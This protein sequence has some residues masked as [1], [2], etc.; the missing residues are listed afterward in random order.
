MADALHFCQQL[1]QLNTIPS[2]PDTSSHFGLNSAPPAPN[3]Q[4]NV[5]NLKERER[6]AAGWLQKA[7]IVAVE[8]LAGAGAECKACGGT[9]RLPCPLCSATG[10]EVVEL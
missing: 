2:R 3:P 9:G 4:L 6:W 5:R 1:L 8:A 7:E 10:G